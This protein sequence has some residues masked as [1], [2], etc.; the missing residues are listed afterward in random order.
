MGGLEVADLSGL[1]TLDLQRGLHVAQGDWQQ[2]HAAGLR[3][4]LDHAERRRREFGQRRQHTRGHLERKGRRI[5]Q[6]A[7]AFI[8]EIL[9]QLH[10]ELRQLR[11]HIGKADAVE[12]LLIALPAPTALLKNR[13]ETFFV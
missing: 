5:A 2:R 12:A 13:L 9:G 7:S 3:K 1:Q 8:F 11:Q 10:T 4:T 6:A